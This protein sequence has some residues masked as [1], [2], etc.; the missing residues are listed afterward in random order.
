MST[1]N[2]YI[3]YLINNVSIHLHKQLQ[4]ENY[5]GSQVTRGQFGFLITRIRRG[6]CQVMIRCP[7]SGVVL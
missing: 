5:Q 6:G 1:K 4:G 3:M 2:L 7:V